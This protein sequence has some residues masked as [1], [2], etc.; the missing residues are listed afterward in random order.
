M[1]I[2]HTTFSSAEQYLGSFIYPLL[3]E[4]RNELASSL[5]TIHS[6]PFAEVNYFDEAKSSGK[7]MYHVKIDHWENTFSDRGKETYKTLP[8]DILLLSYAKPGSFSDL[9]HLGRM[10]AFGSVTNVSDDDNEDSSNSSHFKI[11]VSKDIEFKD[12]GRTLFVIFLINLTTNKRIWNA[13]HMLRNLNIINEVLS[14]NEK[15]IL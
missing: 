1:E 7:L 13:L 12:G 14:I 6:A 11:E 5:E 2:I 10:W 4:T 15:V 8:G 3:E 9:R